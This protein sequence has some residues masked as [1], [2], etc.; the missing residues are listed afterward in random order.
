MQ[1]QSQY[2]KSKIF[3]YPSI[4]RK[5][6]HKLFQGVFDAKLLAFDGSKIPHTLRPLELT[7]PDDLELR[8]PRR[9]SRIEKLTKNKQLYRLAKVEDFDCPN[10]KKKYENVKRYTLPKNTHLANVISELDFHP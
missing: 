6:C 9:I 10:C 3:S 1:Y 8:G 5:K 7:H 4:R 2:W